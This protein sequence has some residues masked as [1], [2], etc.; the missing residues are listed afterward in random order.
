[1][2]LAVP[3]AA[4]LGPRRRW[5]LGSVPL[6]V[7]E[8]EVFADLWLATWGSVQDVPHE[9]SDVTVRGKRES[10]SR[11]LAGLQIRL[12]ESS[13]SQL[14]RLIDSHSSCENLAL[15]WRAGADAS[16]PA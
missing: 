2:V 1:A 14:G 12:R 15:P 5:K 13:P 3:D 7:V 8:P 11:R 10:K 4:R 6:D 9:T 16:V